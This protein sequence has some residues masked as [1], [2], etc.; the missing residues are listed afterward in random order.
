MKRSAAL[1]LSLAFACRGSGG[2]DGE[3]L[4]DGSARA[5][6]AL[7][8]KVNGATIGVDQV[9][10]LTQSTGL[11]PR[12]A[13]TR[14]E[15]EQL[16]AEEARRRGYGRSSATSEDVKRA[17]VQALLAD[18]VEKL[19]PEDIPLSEVRARFDSVAQRAGLAAGSFA[20]HEAAVRAQLLLE[21]QKVALEK[22]TAEL[23]ARI[24]VTLSEP[25][26]QQLLSDSRFWGES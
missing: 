22:L 4:A 5:R 12:A 6:G 9:R 15:E 8:A 21:M 7:V 10:E 1:L 26:V 2:Q 14:L 13:L 18:T 3:A 16:L 23:R 17:L 25:E 11:S 19:R 20:E 24:G